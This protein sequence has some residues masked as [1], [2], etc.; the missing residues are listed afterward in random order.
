M[1]D[2]GEWEC[3]RRDGPALCRRG[4]A[5]AGVLALADP[6]WRCG[7]RR[8]H[9]DERVCVDPDPDLPDPGRGWRCHHERMTALVCVEAAPA[10][11]PAPPAVPDCW[12]D[13][14]CG[15]GARCAAGR[16]A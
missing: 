15:A 2:T 16:C 11:A 1:P 5:A 14:D 12:L 8:G 7:V 6:G 10:P 13:E 9:P 4:G 3:T